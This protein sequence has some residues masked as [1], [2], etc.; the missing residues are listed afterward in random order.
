MKVTQKKLETVDEAMQLFLSLNGRYPCPADRGAAADTP[1]FG[2][3]VDD[4]D[5]V[6]PAAPGDTLTAPGAGGV[7]VRIGAVP[8]RTLNIPDDFI[9]DRWGGRF[10]YAVTARLATRNTYTRTGGAISAIDSAGNSLVTPADSVHYTLVSHGANG[11]G[12][13]PSL[14]GGPL[15][16]TAGTREEENCDN[17]ATFRSSLLAGTANNANLYDDLVKIRAVTALGNTVPAG[18]VMAFDLFACPDGWVPLA[19]AEN[20]FIIGV[21]SDNTD[22]GLT[23]GVE[24]N[25]L[26]VADLPLL[27]IP[28]PVN[29]AALPPGA[30]ILV[31]STGGAGAPIENIPPYVS[32][33]Y[34]RKS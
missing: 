14:G 11:A 25:S 19:A 4:T 13:V 32:Y 28:T 30:S 18:A 1:E 31:E 20:R 29:P 34:C 8:V 22:P 21:G 5:C 16:C 10:T 6:A 12:A 17:D 33:L 7:T 2:V 26:T 23:G 15:P 24:S 9:A 27:A 3:E